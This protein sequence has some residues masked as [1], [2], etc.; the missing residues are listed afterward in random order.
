MNKAELITSVAQKTSLTRKD[1]DKVVAS[2]LDTITETLASGEKV[3]LVGFGTFEVKER[4]AHQGINP[5]T[6]EPMQ[7][8]SSKSAVFKSGKQL[9]DAVN[10]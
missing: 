8:P 10:K 5:S 9:K 7:I 4:A 6:G 1:A 2:V 3:S